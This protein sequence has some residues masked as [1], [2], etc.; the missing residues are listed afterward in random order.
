M[1]ARRYNL[2]K[3]WI[4]FADASTVLLMK[5]LV[6]QITRGK[7]TLMELRFKE[8]EKPPVILPYNSDN[9]EYRIKP[10]DSKILPYIGYPFRGLDGMRVVM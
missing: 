8:G 2:R 4:N 10:R 9:S 5:D 1:V 6:H 7:R 3:E